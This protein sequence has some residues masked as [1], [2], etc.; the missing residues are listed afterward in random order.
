MESHGTADRPE[1]HLCDALEGM[2]N[3]PDES[4]DFIVTS[5]PYWNILQKKDHKARGERERNGLVTDYGDHVLDLGNTK[6]YGDFLSV[7]TVHLV[8]YFRMLR[9]R[10]HAA[11][12]VSDFRK[13]SQYHLFHADVAARMRGSGVCDPGPDRAYPGQQEALSVPLPHHLCP[14]YFQSVHRGGAEETMRVF[15]IYCLLVLPFLCGVALADDKWQVTQGKVA[16]AGE[17]LTSDGLPASLEVRCQPEPEIRLSHPSLSELPSEREDRRSSWFGVVKTTSG[18]GLDLNRPDHHGAT[19]YWWRCE[20]DP[21]CLEARDTKWT[22]HYLKTNFTW[23]IRIEPPGRAH[24]DLRV[25]L[26]GSRKAIESVCSPVKLEYPTD[27]Q[28]ATRAG[29]ELYGP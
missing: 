5:P 9:T 4:V 10:A 19:G 3:L 22:L 24:V 29:E 17:I 1:I 6:N 7:L 21:D 18:F 28:G 11:I 26:R 23:F 27:P 12:I 25:S 13:G 14:Q 8:E 20:S 16:H 15:P 2:S